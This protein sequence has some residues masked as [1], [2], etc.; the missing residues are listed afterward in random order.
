MPTLNEQF[1]EVYKDALKVID[2]RPI[3]YVVTESNVDGL[4]VELSLNAYKE[5][6]IGVR[7]DEG[8]FRFSILRGGLALYNL[9]NG[10]EEGGLHRDGLVFGVDDEYGDRKYWIGPS[11]EQPVQVAYWD[12]NAATPH[13]DDGSIGG[14]YAEY[15]DVA[16]S[17]AEIVWQLA[18]GA[19]DAAS[20]LVSQNNSVPQKQ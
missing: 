1:V 15:V 19:I 14:Q 3:G 17:D 12:Y 20:K 7:E 13:P 4:G 5:P 9:K 16:E 10:F 2:D 8:D 11:D 18:A 6:Y